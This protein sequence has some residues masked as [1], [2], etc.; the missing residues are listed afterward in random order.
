[1]DV[2]E[3][4]EFLMKCREGY[5][6]LP[7]PN[8]VSQVRCRMVGEKDLNASFRYDVCEEL[9]RTLREE[10]RK[11]ILYLLEQEIRYHQALPGGVYE[12]IKL[13]AYLL[14]RLGYVEDSLSIWRAKTTNF[15]THCGI[16]VQL[17]VATGVED[18]L[19][20]LKRNGSPEALAAVGWVEGCR[21]TGDFKNLDG[22]RDFANRYFADRA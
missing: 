6:S 3:V 13:C 2:M 8:L 17:L 22:Y 1:M 10:D 7:N 5:P 20:W 12:S 19:A 16:D 4:S 11:L 15:D 18:T 9:N 21:E 14:F